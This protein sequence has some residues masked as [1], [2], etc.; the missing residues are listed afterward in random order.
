VPQHCF[1]IDD[2][3]LSMKEENHAEQAKGTAAPATTQ[4]LTAQAAPQP[5]AK[6]GIAAAGAGAALVPAPT[7]QAPKAPETPETPDEHHGKGG[8]YQLIDGQRVLVAQTQPQP[9]EI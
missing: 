2:L 5:Q 3:E 9:V 4:A 8:L 6:A 1:A 7:P